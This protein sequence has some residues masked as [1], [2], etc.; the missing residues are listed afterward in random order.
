MKNIAI[1]EDEA[2]LRELLE[3]HLKREGYQPHLFATGDEFLDSTGEG[4]FDLIL[5]DLMLPGT[6]GLDV[7]RIVRNNEET[8]DVPII[9]LTAKSS[10]ADI[11]VG[12]ELG[13]DD[14]MT[15]PFSI[16]ELMAR[17]KVVFRRGER[18]ASANETH[19]QI[20]GVELFPEKFLVLVDKEPVELTATEF[21]ILEYLMRRRGRV[22]SRNQILESLG[23]D[24][25][26]I[27]DRTVDVHVLNI[28]RKL[29]EYSGI[30]QTIRGIGYR[31]LDE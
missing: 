24:R 13:A 21:K 17:I 1:I 31:I 14:Y 5:L 9:M 3:L 19:L 6:D 22:L 29:G 20:S 18:T 26:F 28:R 10:E 23:G 8:R 25:Q 16:R 15:K 7:C 11:V 30:I 2:D 27:I 4:P 12:L